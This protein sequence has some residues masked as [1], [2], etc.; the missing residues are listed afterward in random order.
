M[1]IF[2]QKHLDKILEILFIL[3][4]SLTPL[5]W[6]EPQKMVFGV[7]S[8]YPINFV[9]YFWQRS[10]T[11]LSSIN[12]GENMTTFMGLVPFHG[13]QALISHL[14]VPFYSVEKVTFVF[15]FFVMAFS[16]YLL[17][18][19]LYP[20][21]NF[22]TLRL[23]TVI[24]YVFNLYIFSFWLNGEQ[25]TF[26][27]YASL[28]ILTLIFIKFLRKEISPLK[29][30]LYLNFSYFLLSSGG[31][32]GVPLLGSSIITIIVVCGLFIILSPKK[33]FF[34]MCKRFA[35]LIL[36]AAPFFVLFNAYWL[37]PFILNFKQQF[38]ATVQGNGGLGGNI[39][40]I[41]YISKY[42]SFNNLF[43]LQ[44]DNNWYEHPGFYSN[45]YF[46]N[47]L[48][49]IWSY[50]FPIFSFSSILFVKDKKEKIIV[51]AFIALSLVGLFLSA[52][53]HDP[54]GFVYI[55][56]MNH[57]PGFIA[58][59]SAYYKFIIAV[60]FSFS[61]LF[62][63]SIYYFLNKYVKGKMYFLV[64]FVCMILLLAYNYPFFQKSNFL[65]NPPFSTMVKIP[66]YIFD[67]KKYDNSIE[68]DYRTLVVPSL[69]KDYPLVLYSWGYYGAGSIF[70]LLSHNT[71]I[72]NDTGLLG[73]EKALVSKTYT[74]LE[75]KQ[76]DQF[77]K[78]AQV[79]DIHD[80]LLTEDVVT[81]Y[82]FS[83][84]DS[85]LVY[86]NAIESSHLF[87]TTWKKGPW[88]LYSL[89][90]ELSS[91]ISASTTFDEYEGNVQNLPNEVSKT[92]VPT[93]LQNQNQLSIP[94]NKSAQTVQNFTCLSCVLFVSNVKPELP[95]TYF[96]PGSFIY[97]IKQW[98]EKKSLE[99]TTLPE[100]RSPLLLELSVKHIGELSELI[101]GHP[102]NITVTQWQ[103]ETNQLIDYMNQIEDI[104]PQ[105]VSSNNFVL[106]Q[107]I[108]SFVSVV[109]D[110][111]IDMYNITHDK[112]DP[113][114]QVAITNLLWKEN[115][116]LSKV[117]NYTN[118][119]L[120]EKAYTFNVDVKKND[121]I[122]SIPLE[123]LP[124]DINSSP[125]L[126]SSYAVDTKNVMPTIS[127]TNNQLFISGIPVNSKIM[128]L[129]F[130]SV[131]NLAANASIKT[132]SFPGG[133][134]DCLFVPIANYSW[135]DSYNISVNKNVPMGD[136][137]VYVSA[138]YPQKIGLA[139]TN[140]SQYLRYENSYHF[141]FEKNDNKRIIFNGN[142]D[143]TNASV[144]F[145]PK[146]PEDI[147]NLA[148]DISVTKLTQPVL[149]ARSNNSVQP[150]NDV[151]T[152]IKKIN[153]T[154]Y[155]VTVQHANNPYLLSF[156]ES[157]SPE[158]KLY[159]KNNKEIF[160]PHV[161]VSGYANGWYIS[162]TKEDIF[163]IRFAT[164]NLFV[165]G[166]WVS[167]VSFL[168]TIILTILFITFK[169]LHK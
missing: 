70:P 163:Y 13:L 95:I 71:F 10:F 46:T 8:G 114:L 111:T 126:P 79:L 129:H 169:K 141:S 94:E 154:E 84:T 30:A 48:L 155:E 62:G 151:L 119:Y 77:L 11:W 57:I 113:N 59:R 32:T 162:D 96:L 137:D 93:I 108:D 9:D 148:S 51:L 41:N 81:N 49:I 29:T 143:Y 39:S 131:V 63:V 43:R 100:V 159:D 61:I 50:V 1:K 26:S 72:Y 56:M 118:P 165:V 82:G 22:W 76:Y 97:E 116:V 75:N 125:I 25:T 3:F 123:S 121:Q 37:L 47:P 102:Q 140:S 73:T 160:A 36:Y 122:F 127:V 7:D 132:V 34:V 120:D 101:Q 149:Y 112:Y 103:V 109:N 68:K 139:E 55:F 146:F 128:T 110:T 38:S 4:I 106:L 64:W 2:I 17:I 124:A 65:F 168:T 134:R 99:K 16:M 91:K 66:S 18:R 105:F 142:Q 40:W 5:I 85:P 42:T 90:Q 87:H 138:E 107:Q 60:Y 54:F 117:R 167:C 53:S 15:W 88:T 27:E 21:R 58:F 12:F 78:M 6:F 166:A 158:W 69:N 83:F 80:I 144:Y 33:C 152:K 44:G 31:I 145:C 115:E 161:I 130:D 19:Y 89:N 153:P 92:L 45:N 156:L 23:T 52:G 133:L 147:K 86:K 104:I 74:F 28:P 14:G 157:Y 24:F 67:F 150:D 164:Q 35:L 135:R 136:G 20:Q 98:K